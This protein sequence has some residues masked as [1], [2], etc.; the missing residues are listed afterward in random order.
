MDDPPPPRPHALDHFD[1][2]NTLA[3]TSQ[4]WRCQLQDVI[5]GAKGVRRSQWRSNKPPDNL[6]M[7]VNQI[8]KRTIMWN[9]LVVV[10][11]PLRFRSLQDVHGGWSAKSSRDG[12]PAQQN[13]KWFSRSLKTSKM[14]TTLWKHACTQPIKH[15]M[16]SSLWGVF[17]CTSVHCKETFQC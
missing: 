6:V 10:N 11:Q 4:V 7:N 12:L 13:S 14:A 1:H 17:I 2:H 9:V 15:N 8:W 5:W 16:Y 3:A